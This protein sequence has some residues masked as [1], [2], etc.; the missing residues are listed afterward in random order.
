MRLAETSRPSPR[1]PPQMMPTQ[2]EYACYPPA[3]EA[4]RPLPAVSG[5]H[6]R[7]LQDKPPSGSPLAPGPSGITP[8]SF[9]NAQIPRDCPRLSSRFSRLFVT[10]QSRRMVPSQALRMSAVSFN[11]ASRRVGFFDQRG[12]LQLRHLLIRFGTSLRRRV[13]LYLSLP[14]F[15]PACGCKK[16]S[17]PVGFRPVPATEGV[18][19]VI[20]RAFSVR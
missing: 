15:G 14:Y 4:T 16:F 1:L 3:P 18:G 19:P 2:E 7:L 5:L 20:N 9:A 13:P 12:G 6:R 10:F 11:P 8:G 17:R